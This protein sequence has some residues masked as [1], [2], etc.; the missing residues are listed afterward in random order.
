MIREEAISTGAMWSG[1]VRTPPGSV[2]GWHHHGEHETTI[3]L[4][5]G[6][7]RLE[8]GPGGRETVDLTPHDFCF[9]PPGMVH[10][11]S[12]PSQ[13]ESH[14]VVVRAGSGPSTI[15]VDAPEED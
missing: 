3:F 6:A 11:E 15:N 10:R 5:S 9:V 14:A 4:V 13:E 2:S 1:Y 8:W 7:M 12:N